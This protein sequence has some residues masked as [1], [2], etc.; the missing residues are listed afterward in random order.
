[1]IT[2]SNKEVLTPGK[3]LVIDETMVPWRGRLA[4][5]QYIKNKA[6]K[7]GIKLYKLCTPEGYTSA[8]VVYTGKG[9][10][11]PGKL[12]GT[13]I[14][15]K[16]IDGLEHAGRIVIA[17]NFY[18]SVDLAEDLLKNKTMMCGTIRINRKRL[19]KT[20][21]CKKLKKGQITGQM[22]RAGVKIIKWCDKRA[23]TMITTCKDHEDKVIDT[24]KKRKITGEPILKPKCVIM[25]NNTKKGVDYSDQMTSYYSSLKRGLKWYRKLMM[26]ILFDAIK[27]VHLLNFIE[28]LIEALTKT[29]LTDGIITE[30]KKIHTFQ[31][32]TKRKMCVECYK[33]LRTTIN[34]RDADKKVRR[35]NTYCKECDKTMCLECYNKS[36]KNI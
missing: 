27:K 34:S 13:Q 23:V 19:P 12:H 7:Y 9:V 21:I 16:L 30:K 24:G 14:V 11:Q 35:V 6:H 33:Q 17:D 4:F 5:R 3:F 26:S 20:V 32:G 10:T 1:M 36:H 18:T 31:K 8:I 25:Y 15:K 29:K 28:S 2:R 22:N